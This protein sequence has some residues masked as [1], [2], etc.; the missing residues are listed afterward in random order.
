MAY[1]PSA[2]TANQTAF[3]S[4]PCRFVTVEVATE[5]F[6]LKA[7]HSTSVMLNNAVQLDVEHASQYE[8]IR[9]QTCAPVPQW[10]HPAMSAFE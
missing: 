9:Q 3:A 5:E 10:V 8:Q 4:A 2:D 6:R 1:L 7:F